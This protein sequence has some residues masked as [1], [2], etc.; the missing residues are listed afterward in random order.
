MQ[1]AFK[2]ILYRGEIMEYD[3]FVEVQVAKE[4]LSMIETIYFSKDYLEYRVNYGSHGTRDLL[5]SMIKERY[6][7]D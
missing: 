5:I 2:I 6:N 1:P 4:I 7:I 3:R